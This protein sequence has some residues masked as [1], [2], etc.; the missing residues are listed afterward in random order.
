MLDEGE[1]DPPGDAVLRP[2]HARGS[3]L[4]LDDELLDGARVAAERL[5]PVRHGVA[6][7][8]HGVAQSGTFE[9]LHLGA[10]RLHLGADGFGLGRQ[11]DGALAAHL[12]AG[13]F[14]HLHGGG[15]GV[16]EG[17]DGGGAAQ[18]HVPV[19]LPR[20]ADASVYLDVQVGGE[21]GCFHGLHSGHG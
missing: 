2:L 18:Q 10:E 5:G 11:V 7:V 13:E 12:L 3:E 1:D 17:A 8:D 6:V 9:A 19:V 14:G 16:E 21:V 20:E 4:L 15:F